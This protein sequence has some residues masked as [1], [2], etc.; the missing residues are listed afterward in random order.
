MRGALSDQ[1]NALKLSKVE[2]SMMKRD[3]EKLQTRLNDVTEKEEQSVADLMHSV[4]ENQLMHAQ[5]RVIMIVIKLL[6]F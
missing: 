1:T 5:V 6:P 4:L 2:M 3:N